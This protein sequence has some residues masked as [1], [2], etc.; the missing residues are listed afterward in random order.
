MTV[1][2]RFDGFDKPGY[3][4]RYN[5][6]MIPELFLGLDENGHKAIELRAK[7]TPRTIHGTE[8]IE[9]T[10]YKRP[11]YNTIRF[12]L[13]N[14]EVSVPFCFFCEDIAN[15]LSSINDQSAAYLSVINR[16]YQWK[17]MFMS[18]KKNVL[19]DAEIMGL[20]GEILFLKDNLAKKIGL[21][22][23]LKS[24]SGQELTHKDFSHQN[25]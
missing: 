7:F 22:E 20:I 25:D 17:Q 4:S 18:K 21:S 11:D 1:I 24:W 8:S 19:S 13:C 6:K 9:V 2:E 16:F 23:A 12:S 10:Q 14:D 15:Q 3:F 5:S